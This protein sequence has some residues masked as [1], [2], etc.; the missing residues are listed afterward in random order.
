M[1]KRKGARPRQAQGVKAQLRQ[2]KSAMHGH[3]NKLSHL[4]PPPINYRPYNSLVVSYVAPSAGTEYLI[5]PKDVVNYLKAQLGLQDQT[6]TL[7]VFKLKRIDVYAVPVG[8]STERPAVNMECSSLVPVLADPATPGN[9]VVSYGKLFSGNDVGS[10]QDCAKLSY[11]YPM[12]MA[13]IPLNQLAEFTF[14]EVAANVPNVEV[15][16]HL[17]WSTV[18]DATPTD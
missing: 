17:T 3:Q 10:L 1:N 2:L 11:T 9:A 6:K 13:D 16:F 18:G 4:A 7:I 12:H 8:S 15:R 5:G 14:L